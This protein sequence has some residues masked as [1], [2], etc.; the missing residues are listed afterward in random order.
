MNKKIIIILLVTFLLGLPFVFGFSGEGSGTSGDPYQITTW[1]ELA[2]MQDYIDSASPTY[3]ILN[4]SLDKNTADYN[5]YAGPSANS[6][7]GWNPIGESGLRR[8]YLDGQ[9]NIVSD[10]YI[11]KTGTNYVGLFGQLTVL[12][13]SN[14]ILNNVTILATNQVGVLGG[15]GG[16]GTVTNVIITNSSII[17]DEDVGGLVGLAND[18]GSGNYLSIINSHVYNVEIVAS[19]QV[20]GLVGRLV[21]SAN[22]INSSSY[23]YILASNFEIGG[24]VG[25]CSGIIENSHSKGNVSGSIY[26]GGLVGGLGGGSG[27]A[28]INNSYSNS[29]VSGIFSGGLVGGANG[30]ISNS[31]STGLVTGVDSGGF[32]GHYNGGDILSCFWD[33]QTST[34]LNAAGDGIPSG[35]TGKTTAEMKTLSTFTDWDIEEISSHT[36]EIWYIDD[37]N[38]YP[39]LNWENN[40]YLHPNGVTIMCPDASPGD[41]GEVGGVTYTAVNNTMLHAMDPETD[42][43]TTVCTSLATDMTLLFIT[44]DFNQDISSWDTSSVTH[45]AVM[46]AE[47]PFNQDISYW[48]TSKVITMEGM[49]AYSDFNQSI[50]GWDT[51]SVTHMGHMFAHS[52]FNQDVSGWDTSSVTNMTGMFNNAP[53]FNQDLSRWCVTNIDSKHPNFDTGTTS[54]EGGDATRPQWGNCPSGTEANPYFIGK[55]EQLDGIKN[56]LTASYIL[57]NDLDFCVSGDY[58]NPTTGDI[59]ISSLCQS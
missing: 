43:Y 3:F 9:N 46:F 47:T 23:S 17:G 1:G 40:F 4:N 26:V 32:I 59:N 35:V 45:M 13:V 2:E 10:L 15:T 21:N 53:S 5:T 8:A 38:D 56:N 37:G 34:K 11:N 39:R 20:G 14:L 42:D 29:E 55:I 58:I 33:N 57:S 25:S 16:A 44:E 12:S 54:W 7:T 41:T 52:F 36:D 49:F 18:L 48:N 6:N 27:N 28:Q 19:I 50:N 22:I 24:L 51:S 31:Y 30:K